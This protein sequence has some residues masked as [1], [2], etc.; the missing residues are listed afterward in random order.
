[1]SLR[2][3]QMPLVVPSRKDIVKSLPRGLV[4]AEVGVYRGL[5]SSVIVAYCRPSKH[6]MVDCWEGGEDTATNVYNLDKKTLNGLRNTVRKLRTW[7][8]RGVARPV[9]GKTPEV[10]ALFD[11]NELDF[12]YIDASHDYDAV[13]SDLRAWAP[14]VRPGGVIAGHDY[15]FIGTKDNKTD[16]GVKR[17]VHEFAEYHE[18]GHVGYTQEDVQSFYFNRPEELKA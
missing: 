14:K 3:I 15:G 10:A 8:K 9:I 17:A 13:A 18:V 16:W 2:K 12:V 1:M 11:D 6:Y 5:F 7:I 4:T